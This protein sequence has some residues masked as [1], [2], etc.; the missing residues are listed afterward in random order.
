[1]TRPPHESAARLETPTDLGRNDVKSVEEALNSVLADSFALYMKTKNYHWHVSGPNFRDYH[2][3]LDEHAAQILA[4]T[5]PL[6][7]R[8][9][10]L[11]G[12]TLRS[13]GHI[14]RLAQIKDDDREFVGPREMLEQ[15]ASDNRIALEGLRNAHGICDD[16]N[17]VATASLL[18]NYIDETE[19]RIWFLFEITR[20][21]EPS[22]H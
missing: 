7:E 8:V 14:A 5:D 22:G 6:A 18:E 12:R 13:I 16:A 2:E 11:G 20:P 9:R 17:D 1:M 3:L 19:K 10:K 15:L 4:A 21:A